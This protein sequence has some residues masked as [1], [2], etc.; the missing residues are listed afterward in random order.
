VK[1]AEQAGFPP[2]DPTLVQTAQILGILIASAHLQSYLIGVRCRAMHASIR[3]YGDQCRIAGT[4]FSRA[5]KPSPA[6][7]TGDAQ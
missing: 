7:A 1:D 2:P 6:A 4:N 5:P 3:R